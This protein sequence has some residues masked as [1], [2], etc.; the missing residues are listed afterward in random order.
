MDVPLAFTLAALVLFLLANAFPILSLNMHG[1]LQEA[2]LPGCVR[3][4][5]AL[6]W[7]WLAAILITTVELAPLACLCGTAYV[8]IQVKRR[9]AGNFTGRVFRFVLEFQ[10]WG[11]A[12][13]FILGTLVAYVKLAGMA[14]V[15]PGLSLFALAAYIVIAAE[16]AS[17][18]DPETVWNALGDG[19]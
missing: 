19:P 8:L 14:L 10:A 6:G 4:L 15:V 3:I 17:A 11:M 1:S 9:R 18:L 13:V 2:T 7:P 16:A 5:V 12:E